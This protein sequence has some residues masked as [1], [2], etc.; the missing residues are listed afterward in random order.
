MGIGAFYSVHSN[1]YEDRVW[2]IQVCKLREK[3][4]EIVEIQY[5]TVVA[6]VGSE[7]VVAGNQTFDNRNGQSDNSYTA[8]IPQSASESLTESY[9]FSKTS[10]YENKVTM[11]IT[12]GVKIGFPTIDENSLAV[13]VS[14]NSIWNF[15][16]TWTRSNSKTY[17]EQNGK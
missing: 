1:K 12:A 6:E 3:C 16:Q 9:T 8:T 4:T 7:K 2:D 13:T 17:T 10:G 14:T 15:K 11:G 5:D